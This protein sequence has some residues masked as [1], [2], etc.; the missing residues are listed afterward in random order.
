MRGWEEL[1]EEDVARLSYKNRMKTRDS[2]NR[3]L[4]TSKTINHINQN[5][6]LNTNKFRAVKTQV[7]NIHFD[8]KA[9]A[10][11]FEELLI[12]KKAGVVKEIILQ[13]EY[14]LQEA[15]T[16]ENGE[17]VR[18]IRY[19]ADFKITYRDGTVQV[20]DVKGHKTKEYLLKKK[21]L[22]NKYP[23]LNFIEVM[24]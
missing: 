15:F 23:D 18:A 10:R 21:Q 13:P 11:Y 5:K 8:S 1:S 24:M 3:V 20:V 16:R 14:T 4:N 12:L 19:R 7:R 22:L 6:K 2:P 9:E 17:R